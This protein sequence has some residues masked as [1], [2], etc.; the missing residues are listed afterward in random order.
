MADVAAL[1]ALVVAAV[2][3][4][5][6]ASQLTQQLMTTAYVIRTCDRIVTGGLLEGGTRKWHW[7]KFHFT[8]TYQAISFA[9]PKRLY[10]SLGVSPAVQTDSSSSRELLNGAI[11]LRPK[12]TF[13]Q[14]CWISFV[15]DLAMCTCVRPK[16][17][18]VSEESGDRIPDDLTV[19]PIRVDAIT[20]LLICIAM[21][22][23]VYKY[24][25]TTGEI[26]LAGRVGSISSSSHPLLGTLLHYG[27]YMNH[28]AGGSEAIERNV[29]ALRQKNGVWANA[30]LGRFQ[31]RLYRRGYTPLGDL[32]TQKMGVLRT[33]AWPQD[34]HNDTIGGAACFMAFS[35]VDAFKSVPPSVSRRWCAHFAEVIVSAHCL[36]L[37]INGIKPF[38]LSLEMCRAREHFIDLY[39]C[40]SPHLLWESCRIGL[41]SRKEFLAHL[42]SGDVLA[43]WQPTPSMVVSLAQTLPSLKVQ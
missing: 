28:S 17:L 40:S 33:K 34:S 9:L 14:A 12:R 36:E 4:V 20:V 38:S 29:S 27:V 32:I 6:V 22:M 19:A 10:E 37:A 41:G 3:L 24:S 26:V 15:Q 31:D 23:Q 43:C 7:R 39:G 42:E 16:D 13:A 25:P 21:G 11:Q 8:V 1:A 18:H 30:I 35:H 2:A 5:V